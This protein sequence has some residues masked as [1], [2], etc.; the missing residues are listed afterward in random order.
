MCIVLKAENEQIS[1][2]IFEI[3]TKS[4]QEFVI[5]ININLAL[6]R[7]TKLIVMQL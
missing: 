3:G 7:A 4:V 6:H 2:F 5:Y 1:H